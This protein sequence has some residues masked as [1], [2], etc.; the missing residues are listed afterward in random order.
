MAVVTSP[1]WPIIS[2]CDRVESI[3]TN[4]RER[5]RASRLT[6]R[7]NHP[8]TDIAGLALWV[9]VAT[10]RPAF[11]PLAAPTTAAEHPIR[12]RCGPLR[13]DD[14]PAGIRP[15]PVLAPF[16]ETS[17]HVIQAPRIG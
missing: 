11:F 6:K 15:V 16:P 9:E 7:Q 17:V 8:E 3:K 10:C 12:A 2:I 14:A 13:I 4:N 1:P 5:T